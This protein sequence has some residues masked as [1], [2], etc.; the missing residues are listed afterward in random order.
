MRAVIAWIGFRRDTVLNKFMY[1]F[2]EGF[3]PH[4]T[5]LRVRDAAQLADQAEI[6]AMFTDLPLPLKGRCAENLEVAAS[7][8]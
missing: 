1:D 8:R 3:A 4:L 7:Q 5:Q 2:I 6:D